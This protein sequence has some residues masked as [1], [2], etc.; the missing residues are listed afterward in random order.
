MKNREQNKTKTGGLMALLLFGLF[1]VCMLLVLQTGADVY[2]KL[3]A[4]DRMTYEK[5]TAVQYLTTKVRQADAEGWIRVGEL[6]GYQALVITE[7]I[8]DK[9]YCTWIYC[10]DGYIRELFAAADSGLTADAGE[11]VLEAENFRVWQE[12]NT[13]GAEITATDGSTQQAFFYLRS[14]REVF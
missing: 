14:G 9:E 3:T 4:R 12:M 7:T 1:A 6:D 8:D 5:R 13:I 11:K 2:K 10:Y